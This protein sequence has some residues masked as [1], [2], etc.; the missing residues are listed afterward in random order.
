MLEIK[1]LYNKLNS[2]PE[3]IRSY[4]FSLKGVDI[5][6]ELFNVANV[7][8]NLIG[9]LA[10]LVAGAM[11]KEVEITGFEKRITDLL[12]TA[13]DKALSLAIQ[14]VGARLLIMDDW[15][16]GQASNYLKQHNV[17]LSRFAAVIAEQK[18]A[19]AKEQDYLAGEAQAEK[20]AEELFSSITDVLADTELEL[21]LDEIFSQEDEANELAEKK[22]ELNTIVKEGLIALLNST[23]QEDLDDFNYHFVLLWIKDQEFHDTIA[24]TLLNNKE[25]FSKEKLVSGG[26]EIASTVENL[27][28]SFIKN[29]G[30]EGSDL[31]IAE[32]ISNKTLAKLSEADRV[33]ALRILKF[34]NNINRLDF[35]LTTGANKVPE[36]FEVLSSPFQ[37]KQGASQ[38]P[39][40]S[41]PPP[42]PKPP[43]PARSEA[44]IQKP[45]SQ[46]KSVTEPVKP[47]A[48][49]Q[50]PV[51]QEA[52]VEFK[53]AEKRSSLVDE[54]KLIQR[55]YSVESLEYKTIAQEIRRLE[56]EK[57]N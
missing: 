14:L 32:F 45:L 44:P 57:K 9:P 48:K 51:K 15:L 13:P 46:V 24:T 17:D 53:P 31:N 3:P 41:T 34:N 11:V 43:V 19:I 33:L 7:D 35:Y 4:A 38:A 52:K 55:D 54:L 25:Q 1:D 10:N 27:L 49:R 30:L 26:Q 21:D 6:L 20:E 16:S 39:V 50:E 36:N 47:V 18:E 28:R 40:A 12:Q 5:N 23:Q 2:L 42:A 56:K 37:A 22:K 29:Y 8:R